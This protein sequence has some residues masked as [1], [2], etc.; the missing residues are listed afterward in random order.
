MDLYN[1]LTFPGQKNKIK[2]EGNMIVEMSEKEVQKAGLKKVLDKVKAGNIVI[3]YP[4]DKDVTLLKKLYYI[5]DMLDIPWSKLA[6]LLKVDVKTLLRWRNLE[7]AP[8]KRAEERIEKLYFIIELTEKVLSTEG[9]KDFFK[10][11]NKFFGKTPIEL[12]R[13]G[14][15]DSLSKEIIAMAEGL[16]F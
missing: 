11:P 14:N 4:P 8:R 9:A 7:T 13:E 3:I 6:Q 1:A 16:S 2:L 12:L 15:W 5:K 10:R